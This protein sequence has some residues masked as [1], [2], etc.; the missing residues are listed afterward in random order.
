MDGAVQRLP[1]R[2]RAREAVHEGERRSVCT[3]NRNTELKLDIS[4]QTLCSY[5]LDDLYEHP[6]LEKDVRELQKLYMLR[7]RQWVLLPCQHQSPDTWIITK[8]D[9][10]Y[11]VRIYRFG[12][13]KSESDLWRSG[14]AQTQTQSSSSVLSL[15]MN[16]FRGWR[17]IALF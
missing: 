16:L 12:I 2:R 4:F 1:A 6:A 13:R 10:W 3:R 9:D 11:D 5:V 15:S 14:R 8:I 7:R 17:G